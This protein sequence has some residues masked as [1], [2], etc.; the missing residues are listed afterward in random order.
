[1][2]N[3][4]RESDLVYDEDIE[5]YR[6]MPQSLKE[7]IARTSDAKEVSFHLPP[8]PRNEIESDVSHFPFAAQFDL[9]VM[10]RRESSRY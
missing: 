4:T 9:G 6:K 8:S 2:F 3:E 5:I 7:A 10:R 1:M